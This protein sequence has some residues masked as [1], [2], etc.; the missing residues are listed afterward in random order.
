M[1]ALT[2]NLKQRDGVK[3]ISVRFWA[4][5]KRLRYGESMEEVYIEAVF[6][7][8]FVVDALLLWLSLATAKEEISARRILFSAFIGAS[9]SV[10][11]PLVSRF[12]V[13]GRAFGLVLV[14]LARKKRRR[15][16]YLFS[17]VCFYGYSFALAGAATT[18]GAYS[19]TEGGYFFAELSCLGLGAAIVL[20]IF[21]GVFFMKKIYRKR[22]LF[23]FVYPCRIKFG[24]REV[25]A[26]GFFDSGNRASANG[27]PLCFLSPELVYELLG[28]ETMSEETEIVTASG[29]KRVKI[30]LADELEIYCADKVNKIEKVYFSPLTRLCAKEYKIILAAATLA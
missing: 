4:K 24:E 2:E 16:G 20:L 15:E 21:G 14:L 7:E 23:A 13:L 6:S 25:R 5:S 28:E 10:L 26:D 8:N 18:F 11:Y 29:R 17:A 9:F 22:R 27:R 30:F 19:R 3:R 12:S 1:F